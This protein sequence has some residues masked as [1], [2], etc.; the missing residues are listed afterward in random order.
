MKILKEDYSNVNKI[1]ISNV[2]DAMGRL[3]SDIQKR[4]LSYEVELLH[5]ADDTDDESL[6]KCYRHISREIQD[7]IADDIRDI[8]AKLCDEVR[9]KLL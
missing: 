1:V 2:L 9:E 7:D 3:H 4:L 6:D 8:Y 5:K